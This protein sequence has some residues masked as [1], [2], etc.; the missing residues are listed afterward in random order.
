MGRSF[1]FLVEMLLYNHN[2]RHTTYTDIICNNMLLKIQ[3]KSLNKY[4]IIFCLILKKIKFVYEYTSLSYIISSS[5]LNLCLAAVVFSV[6]LC[7][8]KQLRPECVVTVF[9]VKFVF[10]TRGP[11]SFLRP[12]P[13]THVPHQDERHLFMCAVSL[14]DTRT[15]IHI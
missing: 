14:N 15:D 12:V 1:G 13:L 2:I 9:E 11:Q 10:F 8:R 7:T 4:K 6:S 5:T 3:L